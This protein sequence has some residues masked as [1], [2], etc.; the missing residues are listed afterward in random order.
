MDPKKM[1]KIGMTVSICMGI[2][3]SFFLSLIGTAVSGHF[4]VPGWIISFLISTVVSLV[5]GFIIPMKKVTD[6]AVRA[7]KLQPRSLVARCVESLISDIIYTPLMTFIMV[8]FAYRSALSQGAPA[9][10]LSLG[11]MFF[12]SFW[13][14]LA[15]G[16]LL[17]FIFKPL[18][19]KMAMKRNGIKPEG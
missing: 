16:F 6:G 5:I 4:T 3:M 19:V 7:L 2:T 1:R 8:F 17:I 18:F 9:G 10:S 15:A 14:C 13:I 11:G 12:G